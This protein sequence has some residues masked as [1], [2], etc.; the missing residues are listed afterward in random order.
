[1]RG[2]TRLA[3]FLIG[4]SSRLFPRNDVSNYRGITIL[5]TISKLFE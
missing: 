4:E 1:V 5:S 2:L 3:F